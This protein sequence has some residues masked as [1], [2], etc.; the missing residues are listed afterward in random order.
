MTSLPRVT[1]VSP[2]VATNCL[3]RALL[4]AELLAGEA[5]VQIVGIQRG[6]SIWAPAL[7]SKIPVHAHA[8]HGGVGYAPA[9]ARWLGDIAGDDVMIVSKPLLYS[10]GLALMA[11][12]SWRRLI[13]DIDDWETGFAQFGA[14]TAKSKIEA[15]ALRGLTYLRRGAM[16]AFVVTRLLEAAAS[17]VPVRLVSNRWL[18]RRFGGDLLYHVRNPDVLDPARTVSLPPMLPRERVWVGFVGTPRPH[19]GLEILVEAMARQSGP[20]APGLAVI[21][22]DPDL[23]PGIAYARSRLPPERFRALPPFDFERLWEHVGAVDIIAV[24]SLDVPASRGQIPAKVFDALAM[25][26]PVVATAVND[27][28]DIVE[29]CGF[30]VPP[31][32]VTPMADAIARL[33][34][35]SELR[36]RLGQAGRRK[37][38]ERYSYD[39]GRT[40]IANSVRAALR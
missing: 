15:A 38:I 13:I 20:N 21:G 32:A 4:L 37:L 25:A 36:A 7:R 12:K 24:P 16:N 9:A 5:Q 17:R 11:R 1:I 14:N 3:G 29:G 33:A 26:K 28:E 6:P 2:N 23:D 30:V 35:S 10:F 31:A 22:A 39:V 8:W 40:V 34:A 27:L 19:K 18:Q